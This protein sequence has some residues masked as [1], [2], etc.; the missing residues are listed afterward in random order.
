MINR[1]NL[2]AGEKVLISGIGGG[3]ALFAMQFALALGCEVFVTSGSESKIQK[4]M[5]IGAKFGFLYKD[6]D[7]PKKNAFNIWW[8]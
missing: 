5:K 1:A 6:T 4:A 7:W 8:C 3:V 2:K